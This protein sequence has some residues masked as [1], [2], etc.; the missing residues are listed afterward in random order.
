[1]VTHVNWMSRISIVGTGYVGLSTAVCFALRGH[2]VVASTLS[3]DKVRMINSKKA[4]FHEPGMGDA[5][6]IS[7]DSGNLRAEN[8]RGQAV[9]QTDVTFLAVGTP[10]QA[11]GTIDLRYVI[12]ASKDIGEALREKDTYHL[13]VVKSTVTPGTTRGVVKVTLERTSELT[14]GDDFGL[15]MNPEFLRQGSAIEDTLRPD[16]VVIGEFDGRS[17]RRLEDLL[18]DFYKRSVPILKMGL[19]SAEMVKYASN[20]FLATKISY[21]N[22]IANICE[23]VP[24]LDVLNVMAGVGLDNRI[25]PK[26]LDAGAGFG[27]SCL[28]KDAR[29]L[30]RFAEASGYHAPLLR[31][32]LAVNDAQARHVAQ[33]VL[34]SIGKPKGKKVA[35]L[36]LAFKPNTDDL[37]HAPSLTIAR[38][39]IDAGVLVTAFDPVVRKVTVQ[40]LKALEYARSISDCLA[41]A[42][43]AAVITEWEQ[44]K[45]L[46]PDDFI[47]HMATPVVIDGR[48]IFDPQ[49]FRKKLTFMAV[50]LSDD[51]VSTVC[52]NGD[53]YHG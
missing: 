1:M 46:T 40:G 24:G 48:R 16:R 18:S 25:N 5:L 41:G 38:I 7:I 8:S 51:S 3:E 43:C 27:G 42:H 29:A 34:S 50:G 45:T 30:C 2:Q 19:E 6:N 33:R 39:L 15:C 20:A 22:E 9:R 44:F 14:A 26:F 23:H 49:Q 36:G 35:V 10:E 4:P 13:V 47:R 17:G 12:S 21:A 11:D 52:T 28:P 32:A 31:A 53:S 37:R